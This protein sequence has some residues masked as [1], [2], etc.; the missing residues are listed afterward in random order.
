MHNEGFRVNYAV[1]L[2]NAGLNLVGRAIPLAVAIVAIPTIIRGLGMEQYGVLS[3]ALVVVTYF[4]LF[5]FGLGEATTRF[6]AEALGRGDLQGLPSLI[7]TSSALIGAL[8]LLAGVLMFLASPFLASHVLKVSVGLQGEATITFRAMAAAVPF[9]LLASGL[10]GTLEAKQRYDLVN[11]VSIPTSVANY[12][13]PLVAVLLHTG[14]VPIMGYLVVARAAT[15]LAYF[16][17][18]FRLFPDVMHSTRIDPRRIRPLLTL[19]GWLAISN[20]SWPVLLYMDRLVIGSVMSV[21]VLPYYSAPYEVVTRLWVL[22]ASWAPLY[23]AYST[24]GLGR[25]EEI[26]ELSSRAVKHLALLLGPTVIVLVCFAGTLLRVWLGPQFQAASTAVFR[27]LA[28][29]V[30]ANSLGTVP[31]KLIKG[32]GRPDIIGKVHVAQIPLYAALLWFFVCH[33]GLVGCAVAW[34][35]RASAEAAL[36]FAVSWKLIPSSRSALTRAGV[37]L[38]IGSLAA[39]GGLMWI[40]LASLRGYWQYGVAIFLLM[41]ACTL[42]WRRF[43]DETDR[44]LLRSLANIATGG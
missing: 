33:W 26:S 5:D 20:L 44:A 37:F 35:L 41:A 36:F 42:A 24:I 10:R 17:P 4:S 27:I 25:Q 9:M 28:L 34:T 43:L 3:L 21:S 23:P 30:L 31:D 19:G 29:G 1:V 14:L 16:F 38:L 12:L 7:W 6:V 40:A 32:I 15:C 8:G 13:I 22:P 2:R 18:C 39:F 11:L